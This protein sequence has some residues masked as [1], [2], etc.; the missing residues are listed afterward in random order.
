MTPPTIAPNR[1]FLPH[2]R[3]NALQS[4][5]RLAQHALRSQERQAV[6]AGA[7][8]DRL[9][10]LA[11]HEWMRQACQT[12][13]EMVRAVQQTPLEARIFKV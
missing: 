5:W 3:A 11:D 4:V 12:G 8:A 2:C 10:T 6:S 9:L 1:R 13:T 7:T